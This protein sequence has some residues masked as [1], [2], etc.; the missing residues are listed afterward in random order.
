MEREYFI[1]TK[2]IGF[3]EW[4]SSDMTLAEVLWGDKA[5][6]RYICS[7]GAFRH[8]DIE[9]RLQ[10]E[11]RNQEE[12]HVQY[13]PIFD[14]R[15]NEFIGCCGLRPHQA[16][17]YEIGFHLRPMFWGQ[18]YAVEAARAAIQYA[19]TSLQAESLF[20]GHNPKNSASRHVLE[21]LGFRYIGDEYYE[22]TG[23][24]HPSYELSQT[25]D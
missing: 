17:V 16:G 8:E 25:N 24:Y 11:I 3:S 10:Q 18:G 22:P 20:A 6:T 7:C 9:T 14:L 15:S 12:Y 19:F 2:R 5:V 21:K 1:K 23:L 4:T 13:W